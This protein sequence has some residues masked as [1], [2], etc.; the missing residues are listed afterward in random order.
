MI[1]FSG[2]HVSTRNIWH[3]TVGL[4]VLCLFIFCIVSAIAA[5]YKKKKRHK[6]DE[7]VYLVHADELKF[8]Q[9]G[10]VPITTLLLAPSLA[11]SSTPRTVAYFPWLTFAMA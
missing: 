10:T 8:D 9:Y 3:R 5:P 7:R 11:P 2:I 1:T 4:T 6:T